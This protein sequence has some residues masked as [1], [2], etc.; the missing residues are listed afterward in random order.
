MT[1]T[2]KQIADELE[3]HWSNYCSNETWVTEIDKDRLVSY[4]EEALIAYGNQ[5][6]NEAVEVGISELAGHI[7]TGLPVK[8]ADF[9]LDLLRA[10]KIKEGE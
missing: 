5:R 10:L 6:W 7:Q 3:F 4:V 2:P 9:Y 1:K 8:T